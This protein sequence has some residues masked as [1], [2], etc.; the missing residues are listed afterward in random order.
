MWG[1]SCGM[2]LQHHRNHALP[3]FC[4]TRDEVNDFLSYAVAAYNVDPTRANVAGLSC[5]GCGL[6]EYLAK[7]GDTQIAAAVPIAADGRPAWDT[8]GCDLSSVP[9][10]AL[11]G[12]FD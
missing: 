10:W 2:H 5:G 9:I 11:H 3:A 1:G 8:A 6:W 7:Y 12:E 4:T